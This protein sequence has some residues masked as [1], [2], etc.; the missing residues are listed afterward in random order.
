V[1]LANAMGPKKTSVAGALEGDE[2]SRSTSPQS[3]GATR[4]CRWL[5]ELEFSNSGTTSIEAYRAA[6]EQRPHSVRF[7]KSEFADLGLRN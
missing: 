6:V 1:A 4:N 7:Y 3:Y 2:G 5:K